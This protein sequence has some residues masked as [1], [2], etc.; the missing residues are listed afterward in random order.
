MGTGTGIG[1]WRLFRLGLLVGFVVGFSLVFW[2]DL[3]WAQQRGAPVAAPGFG[4]MNSMFAGFRLILRI[5]V[6]G[7]PLLIMAYY[8]WKIRPKDAY[9]ASWLA[10]GWCG[11]AYILSMN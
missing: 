10:L 2:P 8:T 1:V 11:V 9:E 6:V 7:V 4:D 5:V 3:S